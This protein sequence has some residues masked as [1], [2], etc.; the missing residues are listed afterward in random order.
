VKTLHIN[1]ERTWRGGEQQTLYLA[2]GLAERGHI[3]H[4]VCPPGA[5]LGERARGHGLETFEMS[6]RGELNPVAVGRM[7]K[8]MR[9][10][11]YAIAHM[12][13]S[14]AHTLGCAASLLAGVGR[15]VVSRRVDFSI[16]RHRL[17]VSG[18]KYRFGVDRYIAISNAVKEALIKDGIDRDKISLVHSGIDWQRFEKIEP[19]DLRAELGLPKDA[20]LVGNVAHFGW[21]KA[22][23]YLIRAVPDLVRRVPQAYVL[24]VGQGDREPL[25]REE[26]RHIGDAASH[27][28]FTGFRDDVPRLLLDLD[29]FVMCSVMEGL[30][31]SILDALACHLPV[32]ASDIGG[33]PEIIRDGDTGRLVPPRDPAALA[34]TI[35]EVIESA[36]RGM[37]LAERGHLR[38]Q[39]E[40]S[41]E[42]MV[43]GNLRVY[44]ELA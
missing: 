14:H 32:V 27:L 24:L 40:F 11:R 26:A 31:T 3:A 1:T 34:R 39:R 16:Y 20:V 38:V 4:V 13:T 15:R 23:E 21:H 9:R 8:L 35:A 17:S 41:V 29:V 37:A 42:A 22:Q 10:E 44:R 5:P 25:L 36:D 30:C 28:I 43:E 18:L 33:I 2:A 19:I 6:L 7:A 12:H